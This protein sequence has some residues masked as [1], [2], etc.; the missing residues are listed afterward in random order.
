MVFAYIDPRDV[1]QLV[2]RALET[3]GL[4]FEIFNVA[5]ADTSVAATTREIIDTFYEG[6]EVRR[7]MGPDE[8]FYS[9]DKARDLLGFAPRHSWRDV[10]EDPRRQ[11]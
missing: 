6:V 8:T 2:Q 10:L 9:I 11:A 3:D 7:E 5:N 4:G 1:G